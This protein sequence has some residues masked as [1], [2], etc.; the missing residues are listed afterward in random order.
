VTL[1]G[2]MKLALLP[3]KTKGSAVRLLL[4][5]HFGNE[6]ELKGKVEASQLVA[7]MLA[8]GTKKH[9]FQQ[10]KDELDKLRAELT[11]VE[12]RGRSV[13]VAAVHIKTVRESVP[14]VLALFGEMLR[15]PAFARTELETLRKED[16]ARLEEQLQDP[17]SNSF[18]ILMQRI[19]PWPDDD[20]RHAPSIKEEIEHLRKVQA[21]ELATLHK[22]LWGAGAA[23][24]AIVGDFDEA[25][26]RALVEKQLG[27]WKAARPFERI[28]RP[29]KEGKVGEDTVITPDKQMAFL[30]VGQPLE[31][32]ND[33]PDYPAMVMAN[34]ILGGG[35]S[36]RILN[37]L[38]QKEGL[39]YGAFSDVQ[40]DA[41]DRRGAFYAGAMCA[42][43]NA[44][45]AMTALMEELE[46]VLKS[47]ITDK[48]LAD[49][50]TSYAQAWANHIAD[51]DYVA[52]ELAQGLFT[53][54]TFAYWKDV[55]AKIQKVTRAE[56]EA[57]ARKYIHPDKL[58]RVRAG[59]L[60][61]K[62]S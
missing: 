30:V 61:P 35:A 31:L 22:G 4:T 41:L 15:E 27:S 43:Q 19:A 37:R 12:G 55:N 8:R 33:D 53:G 32:R 40:A 54:R 45:K 42:P 34:Q 21:P 46:K 16:L 18:R 60:P 7:Q 23:Q 47:G 25:G 28:V 48:E 59:D 51:D 58:A 39:S 56:V 24:L 5:L 14:G 50:K 17:A 52:N 1:A 62:K 29:F 36:S 26:T 11:V 9:S 6:K 13:G 10:I 38:R 49:A 44:E 57:A 2:G 3:K 20:V